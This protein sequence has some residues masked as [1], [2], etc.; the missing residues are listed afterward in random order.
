VTDLGRR[1]TPVAIRA[2]ERRTRARLSRGA[3]DLLPVVRVAESV[4]HAR[5][6]VGEGLW[7]LLRRLQPGLHQPLSQLPAAPGTAAVRI[8]GVIEAIGPTFETPGCRG[9][10]VFARTIFVNRIVNEARP[11]DPR[12]VSDE[13]RG[14]DF[15][16]RLDSGERVEVAAGDVRLPGSPRRVLRPNLS[17]LVRRGGDDKGGFL[18]G[19]RPLALVP[20]VR[21]QALHA[22]DTVEAVGVL[23]RE[24]AVAGAAISGRGTPLVTRLV[25][26]AP[27]KP[28]WVWRA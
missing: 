22:G 19:L 12:S 23:L 21:E 28:V 5:G 2:I 11:G 9:G 24:V 15:H 16:V 27:R 26:P 10:A 13:L 7:R 18:L 8:R 25:P 20:L 4:A 14:V 3:G 6:I 1:P 17:E